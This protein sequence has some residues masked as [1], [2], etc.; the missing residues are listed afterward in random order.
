[1]LPNEDPSWD[2]DIGL[3]NNLVTFA[4]SMAEE[5]YSALSTQEQTAVEVERDPRFYVSG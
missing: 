1:M 4:L 3:R 2:M 5:L